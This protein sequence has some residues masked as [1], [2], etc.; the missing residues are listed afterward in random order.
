MTDSDDNHLHQQQQHFM[1]TC[2]RFREYYSCLIDIHS[3]PYSIC[4]GLNN[5]KYTGA[6]VNAGSAAKAIAAMQILLLISRQKIFLFR[7]H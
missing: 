1:V 6:L 4:V 7:C 2:D 3:S 5:L